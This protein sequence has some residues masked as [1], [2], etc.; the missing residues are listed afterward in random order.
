MRAVG[1]ARVILPPKPTPQRDPRARV[2][3]A[4]A[5][6]P[7]SFPPPLAQP[8]GPVLQQPAASTKRPATLPPLPAPL[9]KRQSIGALGSEFVPQDPNLTTQVQQPLP[10]PPMPSPMVPP[11]M[12]PPPL[13]QPLQALAQPQS[14]LQPQ[15]QIVPM[16]AQL[17]VT[18]LPVAPPPSAAPHPVTNQHTSRVAQPAPAPYVPPPEPPPQVPP[19]PPPESRPQFLPQPPPQPPLRLQP[20][21]TPQVLPQPPPAPASSS[22]ALVLTAP[23][24]RCSLAQLAA[25]LGGLP[26][27][28]ALS[29]AA[30]REP[31]AHS[32]VTSGNAASFSFSADHHP[33]G[34]EQLHA[35]LVQRLPEGAPPAE[36]GW[37]FQHYRWIVWKLASQQ[38]C[39][40]SVGLPGSSSLSASTVLL[41]LQARYEREMVRK[42]PPSPS[43]SPSPTPTPSPLTVHRSPSPSPLAAPWGPANTATHRRGLRAGAGWRPHGPLPRRRR[44]RS[45]GCGAD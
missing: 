36:A 30:R 23:R 3:P 6:A 1:R 42:A 11:P 44:P 5:V 8:A 10:P 19:Q 34:W 33:V 17:V 32:G 45:G 35:A 28:R 4:L 41:Q 2:S 22:T 15:Q 16:A 21:P 40:G 38:R 20:E 31:G 25:A 39:F 29:E 12:V 18:P 27:P 43:P 26:T 14:R 13:P 9:G 37:T 24:G 7:F